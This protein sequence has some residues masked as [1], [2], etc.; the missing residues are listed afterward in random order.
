MLK[1]SLTYFLV[2]I[3][4]EGIGNANRLFK[5]RFGWDVRE[6]R[7]LRLVRDTPG[8]TFTS[9]AWL[10][11]F[12]RSAT[13]RILT[14]MIRAGLI[15]RTGVENDGRRY[16]CTITPAGEALC[17]RADPLSMELEEL[18][19]APLT[20]RQRESLAAIMETLLAWVSDGYRARIE[21]RFPEVT[22]PRSRETSK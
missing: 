5:D 12:E 6:L 13:S 11:R 20:A 9:L 18:M 14:R 21:E 17:R 16:T 1:Q 22:A 8:I 10:T 3:A 7:V 19:L 2:S 15:E 4:E